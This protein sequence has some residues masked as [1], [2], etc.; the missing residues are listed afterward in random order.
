[1]RRKDRSSFEFLRDYPPF[2]QLMRL[3]G[4][5]LLYP[6]IIPSALNRN[7]LNVFHLRCFKPYYLYK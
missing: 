5:Y 6:R 2:Q 7:K 4:L 3:K 1:M